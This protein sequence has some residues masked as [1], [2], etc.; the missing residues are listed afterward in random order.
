MESDRTHWDTI[1][2]ATEDSRLGWYEDSPTQTLRL[3]KQ[4]S[5]WR[6]STI[7]L[8]GVGTSSLIEELQA[9]GA[10]LIL[11]DI[12]RE[13]LDRVK[14][15]LGERSET[16][17]WLCQDIAQPIGADLPAV[18]IWID[19][20]VL[21]FL[22]EERAIAGYFENLRSVVTADGHVL[23]AEF[24]TVGA[25]RC[26]GLSLHRYSVEELSDRLGPSFKLLADFDHIYTNP[27]GDPRPYVYA[28]YQRQSCAPPSD[29]IVDR[30]RQ[31]GTHRSRS[32]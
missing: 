10:Q 19:R 28:L 20:A 26:A 15:R 21:H 5:D 23:F 3:L 6:M 18:D 32:H 11:N 12:S 30:E 29:T 9:R 24:S 8:P 22:T 1:F 2:A 27:D 31:R 7:L 16:V 25:P 14:S 13:A 17:L 4:I